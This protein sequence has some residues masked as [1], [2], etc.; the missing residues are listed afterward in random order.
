MVQGV[1]GD[2]L[3]RVGLELSAGLSGSNPPSRGSPVLSAAGSPRSPRPL[4]SSGSEDSFAPSPLPPRRRMRSSSLPSGVL[5]DPLHR[6]PPAQRLPLSSAGVDRPASAPMQRR[7]KRRSASLPGSPL[8]ATTAMAAAVILHRERENEERLMALPPPRLKRS[9]SSQSP[10][11]M[12]SLAQSSQSPQPMLSLARAHSPSNGLASLSAPPTLR[13]QVRTEPAARAAPEASAATAARPWMEH[14]RRPISQISTGPGGRATHQ[15]GE[16][17]RPARAMSPHAH[18]VR[19]EVLGLPAAERLVRADNQ[20]DAL[21]EAGKRLRAAGLYER[22]LIFFEESAASLADEGGCEH[23]EAQQAVNA[24]ATPT[25]TD[26][27]PPAY[28]NLSRHLSECR[29][30]VSLARRGCIAIGTFASPS[31]APPPPDAAAT[32]DGAPGAV[33]RRTM[34]GSA[35]AMLAAIMAIVVGITAIG[36]H[37]MKPRSRWRGD[38]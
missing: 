27:T 16:G 31:R 30:E 10:Q 7:E 37:A 21:Y 18:V 2:A 22:A 8:S 26:A 34:T 13:A 17:Q 3:Q 5:I 36:I 24:P 38:S 29:R 12:L 28:R 15:P 25:S 14:D 20:T 19:L 32:C 33:M 9:Q 4:S 23:E 1:I 35:G 6:L 11:P